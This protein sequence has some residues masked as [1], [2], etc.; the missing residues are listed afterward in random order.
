MGLTRSDVPR[1]AQ[2]LADAIS[3]ER[4]RCGVQEAEDLDEAS[5]AHIADVAENFLSAMNADES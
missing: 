4:V 1:L 5:F 3:D 2:A